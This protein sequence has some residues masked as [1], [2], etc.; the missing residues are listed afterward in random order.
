ML[1]HS[2]PFCKRQFVKGSSSFID[3]DIHEFEIKANEYFQKADLLDGYAPFC[4]H[5]FID[6]FAN[7]AISTV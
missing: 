3:Y 5:V 2:D 6:N 1:K 7:V 4:K